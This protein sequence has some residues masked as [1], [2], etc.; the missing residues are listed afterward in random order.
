MTRLLEPLDAVLN[1][2]TMYR[3][4]L[5]ALFGIWL[6]ALA[7]AAL[8]VLPFGPV[9]MV[10]SLAFL[11]GVAFLTNALFARVFR[12]PSNGES[13]YITVLILA[14]IIS[15]P[16]AFDF[17][18]YL[19]LGAWAAVLAMASKYI[20]AYR[21]KHVFNPAA[22]AVLLTAL[23]L[24]QTASWWVGTA[25]LVVPTLLGGL[26]VARE[27]RRLDLVF[28]FLVVTRSEEHTSELQ[29]H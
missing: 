3:A 25:W 1:G 13:V 23:A 19:P 9:E 28:A 20:V 17:A 22:L 29:S 11:G 26:F 21:H 6:V 27:L 8:G 7:E 24:D 14:L 5:Y 15:P 16:D 10:A 4:T 18:A 2:V 12:V